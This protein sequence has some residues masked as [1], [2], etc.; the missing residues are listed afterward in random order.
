MVE[1]E[2]LVTIFTDAGLCPETNIGTW[3][4]WCKSERGVARAGGILRDPQFSSTM[5]ESAAAVNGIYNALANGVAHPGDVLLIQTDNNQVRQFLTMP[6]KREHK[7]KVERRSMQAAYSALTSKHDVKC[8]FRHVRGHKGAKDKRSAVNTWCDQ[9]CTFF[10]RMAR[11]EHDPKRW[12]APGA[13][14]YGVAA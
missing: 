1:V 13:A 9:V 7:N 4:A 5:A 14:P 12:K 3:A 8:S 11:H 6:V 10:L 2:L